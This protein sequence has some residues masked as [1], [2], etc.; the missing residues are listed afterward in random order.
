M[1]ASLMFL[2]GTRGAG[3]TTVGRALAARL[4]WTFLDADEHLEAAAGRTIAEIFATEGEAGFRDRESA[5]LRGL[6]SLRHHVIATGGGVVLRPENRDL[7]RAAGFT[8]WLVASPEEAF[9]RM[10]GDPTTASRRPNLTAVGGFE[11]L[12]AVMAAR[13]PLYRECA[14]FTLHTAGLSPESLADAILTAWTRS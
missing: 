12:R 6:A 14:D 3:K 5:V 9:A 7:I 13:E 8:A 10:Q 11:E 4:G 2:I 1:P